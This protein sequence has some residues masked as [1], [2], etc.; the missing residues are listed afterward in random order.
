MAP[1]SH[2]LRPGAR[3]GACWPSPAIPS[4]VRLSALKDRVCS[5]AGDSEPN[6]KRRVQKA[7]YF[8]SLSQT[9]TPGVWGPAR[10]NG[11]RQLVPCQA[12]CPVT[13]FPVL[14]DKLDECDMK[15]EVSTIKKPGFNGDGRDA[16]GSEP[17]GDRRQ[18][19]NPT[20]FPQKKTRT[21]KSGGLSSTRCPPRPRH[22]DYTGAKARTSGKLRRPGKWT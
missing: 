10:R 17:F 20:G 14:Y 22:S 7:S 4:R 3:G 9:E 6:G 2:R 8:A 13:G 12:R 18:F 11:L 16:K 15:T 19:G 21:R 5:E 1:S